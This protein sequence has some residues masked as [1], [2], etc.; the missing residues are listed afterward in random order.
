MASSFVVFLSGLGYSS[1]APD[2]F[3]QSKITPSET[4]GASRNVLEFGEKPKCLIIS[5][6]NVLLSRCL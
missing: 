6:F 4:E 5:V 3:I 2:E 1:V